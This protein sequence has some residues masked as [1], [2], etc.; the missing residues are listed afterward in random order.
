M[1]SEGNDEDLLGAASS[2]SLLGILSAWNPGSK[3]AGGAVAW[4]VGS[5]AVGRSSGR[6]VAA[7]NRADLQIDCKVRLS[8]LDT[9]P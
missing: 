7:S 8:L 2:T 3:S 6:G 5:G 9:R 4:S 1:R